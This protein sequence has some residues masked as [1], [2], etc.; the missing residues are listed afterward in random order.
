MA[1]VVAAAAIAASARSES[2]GGRSAARK[3]PLTTGTA[4]KMELTAVAAVVREAGKRNVDNNTK[5]HTSPPG[6]AR[7]GASPGWGGASPPPA[8][9]NGGGKK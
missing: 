8:R 2:A 5:Q 1:V 7:M 4:R 3:A 9:R 6:W